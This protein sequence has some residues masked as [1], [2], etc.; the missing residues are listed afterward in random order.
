MVRVS[1]CFA[2]VLGI[3]SGA[4][5]QTTREPGGGGKKQPALHARAGGDDVQVF[6]QNYEENEDG[7]LGDQ[8]AECTIRRHVYRN[9]RTTLLSPA[10]QRWLEPMAYPGTAPANTAW[11]ALVGDDIHDAKV[12]FNRQCSLATKGYY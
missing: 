1:L 10:G 8:L 5:G 9:L 4:V 3:V 6:L 11:Y 7:L 2:V 12:F